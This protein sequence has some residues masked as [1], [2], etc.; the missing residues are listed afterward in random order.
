MSTAASR[1][2]I[3][4]QSVKPTDDKAAEAVLGDSVDY[5]DE[6]TR[7]HVVELDREFAHL[8]MGNRKVKAGPAW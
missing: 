6:V 3:E 5:S 2:S 4:A 1:R 7:E 8:G